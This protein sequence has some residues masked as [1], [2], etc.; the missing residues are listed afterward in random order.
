MSLHTCAVS[1]EPHFSH[2][3]GMEVKES[4]DKNLD[5]LYHRIR[6]HGCLKEVLCIHAIS[7]KTSCAGPYILGDQK[8]VSANRIAVLESMIDALQMPLP[9]FDHIMGELQMV[10]GL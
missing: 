7:T 9:N 4:T 3:Q 8:I 10:K 6:Q 1:S 5:L 2:I